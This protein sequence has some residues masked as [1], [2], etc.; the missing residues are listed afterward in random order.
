MGEAVSWIPFFLFLAIEGLIF[1]A[2][3]GVVR[4]SKPEKLKDKMHRLK[5]SG[6]MD[7]DL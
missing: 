5:E 6:R 4:Y 3:L 1:A 2:L 7:V